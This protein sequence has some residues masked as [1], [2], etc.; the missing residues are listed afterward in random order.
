MPM[1]Y[2]QAAKL[3]RKQGGRFVRH[4]S[5]HDVFEAADG[6]EI[7]VPRHPRDITVGVEKD[8]KRKLGLK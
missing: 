7:E 2:R 6:T 3:I 8:I 1:N 5:R 4:G